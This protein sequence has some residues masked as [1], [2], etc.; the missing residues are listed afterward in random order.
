MKKVFVVAINSI[1]GDF[2]IKRKYNVSNHKDIIAKDKDIFI[3]EDNHLNYKDTHCY[4]N[5]VI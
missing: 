3:I 4:I 1:T 5:Y 2:K